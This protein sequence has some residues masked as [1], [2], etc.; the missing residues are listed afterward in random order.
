MTK[1]ITFSLADLF[2]IING[3]CGLSAIF[4]LLNDRID[5]SFNLILLS[6][7]SDGMDGII[8]RRFGTSG[9]YLDEIADGISF[10]FAPSVMIYIV[11]NLPVFIRLFL[12]LI[13]AICSI[14]HLL[15][16]YFGKKNFF[17]GITTPT[18][19]LVIVILLYLQI[20][21]IILATAS[22]IVSILMISPIFYP[23]LKGKFA[24]IAAIII[25]PSFVFGKQYGGFA[26]V[27]LLTGVII[28]TILGPFYL[29]AKISKQK[30]H[31][32]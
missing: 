10:V 1:V 24:I 17:V 28:Y 32:H 25:F 26:L 14:F 6:V 11:S 20:D 8:A 31:S 27:L 23:R 7:L 30:I 19:A 5:I 13:F 3:I 18:A 16:Y 15:R 9:G 21:A 22:M 2:T 12:C 29:K 4:F